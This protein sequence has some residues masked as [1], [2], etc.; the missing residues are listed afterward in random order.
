MPFQRRTL[1]YWAGIRY[2]GGSRRRHDKS[3]SSRSVGSITKRDQAQQRRQSHG[4]QRHAAKTTTNQKLDLLNTLWKHRVRNYNDAFLCT[5]RRNTRNYAKATTPLVIGNKN[6]KETQQKTPSHELH[7]LE[8][9]N[10]SSAL[11]D[12]VK[13][14]N[15]SREEA[16]PEA[17]NLVKD[18]TLNTANINFDDTTLPS[19]SAVTALLSESGDSM[20]LV[21]GE[22]RQSQLTSGDTCEQNNATPDSELEDM[23]YL[24]EWKQPV[25]IAEAIQRES[26]DGDAMVLFHFL[27][28]NDDQR[29]CF[30]TDAAPENYDGHRR[31]IFCYFDGG[32]DAGLFMHCVT[33]HGQFLSFK[34]ARSEDGT[35]RRIT[36]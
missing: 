27:F 2:G 20:K 22:L 28:L 14:N 26:I 3:S 15:A 23:N 34:A 12:Q 30:L 16:D 32:T 25:S 24:L 6:D 31:C 5:P 36:A 17:S 35:V 21:N 9:K 1:S 19:I 29:P 7:G 8:N 13:G 11:N 18:H 10:G 4:K 33:C